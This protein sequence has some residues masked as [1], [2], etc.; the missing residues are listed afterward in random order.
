MRRQGLNIDVLDLLDRLGARNVRASGDEVIFSCLYD[1]DHA[2][3]DTNPSA[4]MNIQTTAW[5]CFGCQRRG[6]AVTLVADTLDVPA[7]RARRWLD[8]AYGGGFEEP[9]NGFAEEMDRR[10]SKK[11]P[12]AKPTPERIEAPESYLDEYE[13]DWTDDSE[14]SAYMRERG[15]DPEY[16]RLFQI[17]FSELEQRIIIPVRYE[18][19]VLAGFKGRALYK[20]QEP[21][22]KVLG[23]APYPFEPYRV[24]DVLF[25]AHVPMVDEA[26]GEVILREGE[27]NGL[28]LWQY[29]LSN[30]VATAGATVTDS[31]IRIVLRR[32]KRVTLWFDADQAGMA[33]LLRAATA[34][35][36]YMPVRV[37]P[38]HRLD[39]A[40]LTQEECLDLFNQ[41]RPLLP[42][43]LDNSDEL[44]PYPKETT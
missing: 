4:S 23:R 6:N 17:G 27:L 39:P 38:R 22:Y 3:G 1:A 41:A 11:G 36:P 37:V 19:G 5:I 2:H 14:P 40:D 7:V 18:D 44:K 16:L 43:Y 29:G 13:H 21:R 9:L 26:R 12:E 31:Q 15:F 34:L 8:E 42:L 35:S 28:R 10:L 25:G 30:V 32:A 24:G 33:G 20:H